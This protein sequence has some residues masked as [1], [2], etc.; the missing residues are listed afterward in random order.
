MVL[1]YFPATEQPLNIVGNLR[2]SGI[3]QNRIF[4]H[5]YI[6]AGTSDTVLF[7]YIAIIPK[8]KKETKT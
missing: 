7:L 8:N 5:P 3:I 2:Q 6:R 1:F 4:E